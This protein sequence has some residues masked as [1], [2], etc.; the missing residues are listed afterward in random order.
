MAGD[1]QAA[2]VRFIHYGLRFFKSVGRNGD[3]R[4]VRLPVPLDVAKYL[5]PVGGG[6]CEFTHSLT[7][8]PG[9]IRDQE[10]LDI[11]RTLWQDFVT[12]LILNRIQDS[13]DTITIGRRNA[14]QGHLHPWT[15]EETTIDGVP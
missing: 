15:L 6:L 14:S 3:Q 13:Y 5:D 12:V 4:A 9:G 8:L 1:F 11:W 2:S 7:T 10:V